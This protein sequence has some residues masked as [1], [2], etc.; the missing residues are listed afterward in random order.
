MGAIIAV[1][2][3]AAIL[4]GIYRIA[5]KEYFG[6]EETKDWSRTEGTIVGMQ[7]ERG[8]TD[9]RIEFSDGENMHLGESVR[10]V[11]GSRFYDVGEK[12]MIRYHIFHRDGLVNKM[13]D[14]IMEN[15]PISWNAPDAIVVLENPKVISLEKQQ[16]KYA[17]LWLIPIMGLVIFDIVLI[18]KYILNMFS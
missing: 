17:S 3:V 7:R 12:V 4:Y 14:K 1:A 16:T 6:E 10:Y 11:R 13:S 8:G 2:V 18:I 15:I 5:K 9:L